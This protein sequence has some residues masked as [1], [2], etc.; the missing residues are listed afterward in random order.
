MKVPW[1][2]GPV[3][4]QGLSSQLA[5]DELVTASAE[6]TDGSVVVCT[7]RGL[8][9][10]E[11][12]VVDRLGWERVAKAKLDGG[13]LTITGIVEVAVWADGTSVVT[14]AEPVEYRFE[15]PNKVTDQVHTRVRRSVA[16]SR[17]LP[18]PGGGG[19]VALRRIPGR[20]GLH[21]QLRLDPGADP[22]APGLAQAVAAVLSEL[23]GAEPTGVTGA[24]DSR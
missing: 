21:P 2:R 18:W 3:L 14:D 12:Q 19:W 24:D 20:D 10:V 7:R 11:G 9:R 23:R 16:A 22:A 17:H 4:P 5:D 15:R 6:T 8:W 13:R 1:R